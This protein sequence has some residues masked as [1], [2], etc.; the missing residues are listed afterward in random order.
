MQKRRKLVIVGD[1]PIAEIVFEYFR[2]DSDYEVRA[3][4]VE[5]DF[6]RRDRLFGLP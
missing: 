3:L 1:R 2:H 5:R 6:I 4:T